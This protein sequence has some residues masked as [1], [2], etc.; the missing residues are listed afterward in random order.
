MT[1]GLYSPGFAQGRAAATHSQIYSRVRALSL[2]HSLVASLL[3]ALC[4]H[5]F[6]RIMIRKI[7]TDIII[8]S[9]GCAAG[10]GT[11]CGSFAFLFGSQQL[12]WGC[13]GEPQLGESISGSIWLVLVREPAVQ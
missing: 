11:Q 6:P 13:V 7:V 3:L 4:L 9:A 10:R 2:S 5:N 12:T 1:S 8:S